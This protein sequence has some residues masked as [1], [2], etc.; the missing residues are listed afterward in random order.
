[1]CGIAYILIVV[2]AK[3]GTHTPQLVLLKRLVVPASHNKLLLWLWVPACA[4]TTASM[5]HGL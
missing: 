4:G 5:W 2:P 1:M 3:A